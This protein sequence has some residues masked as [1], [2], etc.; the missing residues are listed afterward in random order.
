MKQRPFMPSCA[1]AHAGEAIAL[2]L[3]LSAKREFL[4]GVHH[5]WSAFFTYM[6]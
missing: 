3:L 2:E 6:T 1:D 4:E 5:T